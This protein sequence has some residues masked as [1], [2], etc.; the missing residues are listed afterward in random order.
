MISNP[1]A[2]PM[3]CV[4]GP[5][6]AVASLINSSDHS[7]DDY[8]NRNERRANTNAPELASQSTTKSITCVYDV[9]ISKVYVRSFRDGDYLH[10][11][12][13]LHGPGKAYHDQRDEKNVY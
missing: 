13:N 10:V 2:V 5:V 7:P 11:L 9:I 1:S 6:T 3:T 4:H 12:E 8:K